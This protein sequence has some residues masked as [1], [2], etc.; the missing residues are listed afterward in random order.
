MTLKEI[1]KKT[2]FAICIG[3]VLFGILFTVPSIFETN[4]A[5]N[6]GIL[7]VDER[8]TKYG[9]SVGMI[10]GMAVGVGLGMYFVRR[11]KK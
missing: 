11:L 7:S 3:V 8:D 1:P 2:W 10:F 4:A 5:Y 6:A 9:E